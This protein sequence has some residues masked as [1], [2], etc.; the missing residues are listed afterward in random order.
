MSYLSLLGREIND[1]TTQANN[2]IS[3]ITNILSNDKNIMNVFD[4][5]VTGVETDKGVILSDLLFVAQTDERW[6]DLGY[7][8]LK[9]GKNKYVS[10]NGCGPSSV[11][12]QLIMIFGIT[13]QKKV[14][15]LYK[16]VLF[17][18]EKHG[19]DFI[20]EYLNNTNSFKKFNESLSSNLYSDN[21]K[22][23][24]E[25]LVT[26]YNGDVT[27]LGNGNRNVL[28]NLDKLSFSVDED[29]ILVAD[30]SFHDK[31]DSSGWNNQAVLDAVDIM[32][33]KDPDSMMVFSGVAAGTS[34]LNRPFR[35]GA[36]GHYFSVLIN[37]KE[38]KEDGTIYI[39]DSDPKNISSESSF[40]RNYAF[41]D[42]PK[43]FAKF[44]STYDVT[45]VN[46][47]VLEVQL[48]DSET[49][50]TE[51]L[52][53]LGLTGGTR[54]MI[55]TGSN[56]LLDEN[57]VPQQGDMSSMFSGD[58]SLNNSQETTPPS[59]P[60]PNPS[61]DAT[62]VEEN[63]TPEDTKAPEKT[64][65]QEDG[66]NTLLDPKDN[67]GSRDETTPPS[68][69]TPNPSPTRPPKSKKREVLYNYST[70]TLQN[71]MNSVV[72]NDYYLSYEDNTILKFG[73]NYYSWSDIIGNYLKFNN[74]ND[75][76]NSINVNNGIFICNYGDNRIKILSNIDSVDELIESLKSLK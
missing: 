61:S 46:D 43:T 1:L 37:P 56:V 4:C 76:I 60:T 68:N 69:P 9:D 31:K 10:A 13:D 14:D 26:G 27:Y 33:K 47:C 67:A 74:L 75:S 39:L 11:T 65:P 50:N 16:E 70:E 57:V 34:K 21:G 5:L 59:N 40:D 66:S 62:H 22:S 7:T 29:M 2:Y 20:S 8:Y 49:F 58:F 55:H 25:S 72:K 42:N 63:P 41:V 38:F 24:L 48:K 44:M 54:L 52:S 71:I 64:I 53:I 30:M 35:G 19:I 45:R 23:M 36:S 51:N 17:L 32:Y 12:N 6:R 73:N 15:A 28:A 3:Q 18:S